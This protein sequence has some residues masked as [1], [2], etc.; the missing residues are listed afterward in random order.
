[1]KQAQIFVCSKLALRPLKELGIKSTALAWM[2]SHKILSTEFLILDT[3]AERTL[4]PSKH[5]N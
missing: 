3:P 1:M 2:V 4:W 5:D